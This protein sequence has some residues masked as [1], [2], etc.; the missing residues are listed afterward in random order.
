MLLL[1]GNV[2]YG[3]G[4]DKVFLRVNQLGYLPQDVKIALLFGKSPIREMVQLRRKGS[5]ELVLEILPTKVNRPNWG[6]FEHYY[7]LDFSAHGLDGEYYLKTKKSGYLSSSFI[8]GKDT[9]G[10]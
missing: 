5:D 9:Y 4:Q 2:F 8:I 3:F 10:F 7:E 6:T 1:T